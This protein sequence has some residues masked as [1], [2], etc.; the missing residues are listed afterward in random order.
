M[1]MTQR[2]ARGR[3]GL[4][5]PPP[6][7][8]V[9]GVVDGWWSELTA[10]SPSNCYCPGL[11]SPSSCREA[12]VTMAIVCPDAAPSTQGPATTAPS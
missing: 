10:S 11:F 5:S 2:R 8:Q 12:R 6:P 9:P 4:T 3:L 7:I 1:P